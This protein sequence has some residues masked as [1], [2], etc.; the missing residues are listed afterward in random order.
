LT[1]RALILEDEPLARTRLRQLLSP[2]TDIDIV[3]ECGST[4]E[5]E[6]VI[7]QRAPELLFVDVHLPQESGMS[8]VRRLQG[9]KQPVIVFTTADTD[10]ALES[11]EMNTADYLVK[12][13]DGERVDRALDRARRLLGGSQLRATAATPTPR[14]ERRDRFGVRVRGE[15]IFVRTAHIDWISAEGNYSRLH[16]GETSYLLRESM[17]SLEDGLDPNHFI[18][19]HRSA[20]V[21]L[22]RVQKLVTGS[23][24]ALSIVLTTGAAVPLGPSYRNRLEQVLGQKL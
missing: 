18:R 12:P 6:E 17:Q 23:D 16:T 19:V 2:H 8:F 15:I 9:P 1:I 5:A 3:A 4:Q 7:Q 24:A 20:I 21:N 13:F 14:Q 22:D 10:H 11:Y